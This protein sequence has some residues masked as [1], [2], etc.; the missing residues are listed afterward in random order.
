MFRHLRRQPAFCDAITGFPAKWRLRKECRNSILMMP[1]LGSDKI[2]H[3]YGISVTIFHTSFREEIS[4]GFV[5]CWL[6]P[7]VWHFEG[8][9]TL[10][11]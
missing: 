7:H 11:V 5:K 3:K 8:Q 1:D 4:G 9:L 2:N 10:H 6:F